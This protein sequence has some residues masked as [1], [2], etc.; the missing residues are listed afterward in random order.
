MGD[1]MRIFKH[2]TKFTYFLETDERDGMG[3]Q[4]RSIQTIDPVHVLAEDGWRE[5]DE[6]IR[7][8]I[9][10]PLNKFTYYFLDMG[11]VDGMG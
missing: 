2:L 5:R 1:Q 4:M 6:I 8:E 3:D 11:E 9:F 10:K 7:Y